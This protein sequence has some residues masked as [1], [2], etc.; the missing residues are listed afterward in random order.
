MHTPGAKP[1]GFGRRRCRVTHTFPASLL[2]AALCVGA[3]ACT[4]APASDGGSSPSSPSPGAADEGG[5]PRT[6]SS[7]SSSTSGGGGPST[8]PPA[9]L[10]AEWGPASCPTGG[11]AAGFEVGNTLADLGL[12][13]CDTNAPASLDELCGA[14]ATWVFVAHTHCPTCQSTAGFTDEVAKAV[15]DKNVAIAHVVHDDN[16]TSC[17]KWRD[18]Y[19]LAG[20]S[21]ARVYAD[22]TGAAYAK[23][24]A[25]SFTA[26]SAFL[27]AN[28]VITHKEHGM[29][30]SAV[31]ERLDAALASSR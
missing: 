7:S 28:R 12:Q 4:A 26:P 16:G 6:G 20:L 9:P 11:P 5:P 1:G 15:A 31:L 14:S 19:K 27:D 3:I 8:A 21:N 10:P 23:L 2:S 18:V 22:P 24:K 29:S 13:D 17:A 30:K 25:S